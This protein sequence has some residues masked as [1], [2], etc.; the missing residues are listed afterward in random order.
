MRAPFTTTPLASGPHRIDVAATDAIG[1]TDPTP[2]VRTFTLAT[3]LATLVDADHDGF[4]ES[5]DCDD[6]AAGT[7]PGAAELPGNGIDENCDAVK[8]PFA[9]VRGNAVLATLFERT[10][11]RL[12]TL[13]V[14]DLAAG[15]TVSLA[16]RGRGCRRSTRA[17]F[18]VKRDTR[19]L[20]V[21]H[22][23][24]GVRLKKGA[25]VEVRVAHPGFIA[26]IIRFTIKHYGDV[27]VR[28][29]LCQAPGAKRPGRC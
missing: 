24:R 15:D 29:A 27:P 21:S 9:Q 22:H 23:V 6:H 20:D 14:S 5:L 17:T 7:H 19:L 25:V 2:A 1:N 3:G 10:A 28:S 4:P 13:K 18:V 16:C 8:A 11:T 26:R 12:K